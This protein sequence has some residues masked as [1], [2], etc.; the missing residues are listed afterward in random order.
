MF[1]LLLNQSVICGTSALYMMYFRKLF[2][3]LVGEHWERNVER[4]CCEGTASNKKKT[5]A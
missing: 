2:E 1:S 5:S 4:G 3:A